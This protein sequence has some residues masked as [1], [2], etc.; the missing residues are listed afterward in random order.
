MPPEHRPKITIPVILSLVTMIIGAVLFSYSGDGFSW[1]GVFLVAVNTLIAI[2]DRLLQRR[3][4]VE[5]CKDLPAS[6]CCVVS[7]T[8]GLIP[9][10]LLAGFSHEFGKVTGHAENWK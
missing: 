5:E 4:L 3:L 8:I 7:N 2:L 6:A 1:F 9:S 10:L